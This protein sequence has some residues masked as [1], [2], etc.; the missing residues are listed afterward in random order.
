[1]ERVLRNGRWGP[2][3]IVDANEGP[4]P[5]PASCCAS[6]GARPAA[7]LCSSQDRSARV[8]PEPAGPTRFFDLF[9]GARRRRTTSAN[10]PICFGSGMG[11]IR[12]AGMA[13]ESDNMKPLFDRDPAPCAARLGMWTS[14]LQLAGHHARLLLR[15]FSVASSIGRVHNR[16]DSALAQTRLT[17]S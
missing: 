7:E 17:D 5:R 10:F 15:F 13:T 16:C 11:G 14:P 4:M 9:S 3:L 6:P 12:Q 8:D 2:C 1:V